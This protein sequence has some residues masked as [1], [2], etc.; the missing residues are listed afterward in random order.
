[1][2]NVYYNYYVRV[3]NM[4]ILCNNISNSMYHDIYPNICLS[5][6]LASY[7][8]HN[9]LTSVVVLYILTTF[10]VSDKVYSV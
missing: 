9:M 2:S 4:Y 3:Q 6:K 8:G 1:M 7:T 5:T 10:H